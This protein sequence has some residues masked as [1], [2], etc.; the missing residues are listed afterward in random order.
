MNVG[1]Q[2]RNMYSKT[3][4]CWIC[5]IVG[6]SHGI[7]ER[8]P[9]SF[10]RFERKQ[11]AG[12]GSFWDGYLLGASRHV[13]WVVYPKKRRARNGLQEPS[14][15]REVL[16]LPICKLGFKCIVPNMIA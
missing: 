2:E 16:S 13:S 12:R 10:L 4:D 9:S 5:L 6:S 14:L 1:D 3:N 15:G 8:H 7:F 11:T